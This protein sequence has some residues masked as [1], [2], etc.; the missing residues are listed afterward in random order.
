M[1]A[2]PGSPARIVSLLPSATEI[3]FAIGAGERV[4]AVTHECDHP[5]A[6][7]ALPRVTASALPT[8]GESAAGID[9]H[10]R[11]ALHE[12]SSIYSLDADLLQRLAPELIVTQELCEVCA[13][14]YREVQRA[15]RSLPG[16][17]PVLSLEP[18]SLDDIATTILAV[19]RATGCEPRAVQVVAGMRE[20]I[21]VVTAMAPPEPRPVVVC[22]E[23]TDPLMAGGHWVPEMV[24]LAGGVDPLGRPGAPSREVAWSEVVD[25]RPDVIVLMPCGFGLSC[26]RPVP[27]EFFPLGFQMPVSAEAALFQE[28]Q[29]YQRALPT[30]LAEEGKFAVIHG[31]SVDSAVDAGHRR[32]AR[33][34]G[35]VDPLLDTGIRAA[36]N[37]EKLDA[38]AE[39]VSGLEILADATR[40][41][42]GD[43]LPAGAAWVRTP[44]ALQTG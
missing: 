5:V 18:G 16:S 9:R 1:T 23:W 37:T 12:G 22:L 3:L 2:A 15:V 19:G 30:L 35:R 38:V 7:A 43:P 36:G 17:V 10:I 6:A 14:S 34:H 24:A 39:F 41:A 25:A 11:R 8:E 32:R 4:V 27:P 33:H 42:P 20:R 28:L 13:V 44:A 40:A 26:E 21:G 29:T 31:N